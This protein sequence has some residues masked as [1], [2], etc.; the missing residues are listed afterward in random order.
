M[1]YDIAGRLT[2]YTSNSGNTITYAYVALGEQAAM[3]DSTG[4]TEYTY[5]S[6]GRITSVTTYRAT[7][8]GEG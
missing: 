8:E 4:D 2:S 5:D 3:Y 7:G 6:L 1:T